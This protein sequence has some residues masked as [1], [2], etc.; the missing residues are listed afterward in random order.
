MRWKR[1]TTRTGE[2]WIM[3]AQLVD[4]QAVVVSDGTS[5]A[6]MVIPGAEVARAL[7]LGSFRTAKEARG[8][9]SRKL[10]TLCDRNADWALV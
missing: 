4:A 5:H 3:A 7:P 10:R 8:A 6:A 1:E 9:A 2:S